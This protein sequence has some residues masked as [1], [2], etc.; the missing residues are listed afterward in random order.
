MRPDEIS[1][2]KRRGD[3]LS[4][5]AADAL[6]AVD[7]MIQESVRFWVWGEPSPPTPH[8]DKLLSLRVA[9]GCKPQAER[10]MEVH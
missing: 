2:F 4:M 5:V 7:E 6:L 10:K 9:W 8:K 3:V 1:P